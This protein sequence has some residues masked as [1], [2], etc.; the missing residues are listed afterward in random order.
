M[1]NLDFMSAIQDSVD[2]NNAWSAQQADKQM[3][4][5]ERMSN[6]AFQRQVADLKAAGLNPVLSARL[7]GA[8]TPNGAMASGDNS[9][10]GAL[11]DMMLTAMD[12]ANS[13]AGAARAVAEEQD[14]LFGLPLIKNPTKPWQ[15][16][17]N[18]AITHGTEIQDAA[19]TAINS[20][21]DAVNN[22]PALKKAL[23]DKGHGHTSGS[24]KQNKGGGGF[25]GGGGGRY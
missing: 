8:S 20:A 4:F 18:W 9:G 25:S 2:R 7:G 5:Q 21:R 16:A 17:Y 12:T 24:L 10:T 15:L 13:A 23:S 19:Q 1:D 6:T 3:A 11:V 22:M 14:T